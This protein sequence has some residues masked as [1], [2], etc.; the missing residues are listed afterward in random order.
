MSIYI[1]KSARY[2]DGKTGGAKDVELV[3]DSV[4]LSIIQGR[5][6]LESWDVTRIKILSIPEAPAPASISYADNPDARILI[7]DGEGWRNL[8]PIL[9]KHSKKRFSLPTGLGAFV[10]YIVVSF[11]ILAFLFMIFPRLIEVSAYLIPVKVEKMIGDRVAE[12]LIGDDGVCNNAEGVAALD[13]LV[14]RLE[15]HSER[16]IDYNVFV[17]NNFLEENA[18]SAP[19]GNIVFYSGLIEH[20]KSPDEVA[21]VLAHEMA[22]VELYH[23]TK[24][25]VRDLGVYAVLG[26]IFDQADYLKLAGFVNQARY[27]QEDEDAADKRGVELLIAAG[28]NPMG[29]AAFF[30]RKSEGDKHDSDPSD[31]VKELSGLINYFSSH[32]QAEHRIGR[33]EALSKG[34]AKGVSLS[35]KEWEALRSICGPRVKVPEKKTIRVPKSKSKRDKAIEL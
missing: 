12:R 31:D 26:M 34:A 11:S 7:E 21:G 35:D 32:P 24:G 13:K 6:T 22:H 15:E 30:K 27:S 5:D 16:K 19:G 14:T 25:L 8:Y 4:A 17:A 20:A 1:S 28:M 33:V 2:Y 10:G 18:F 23:T 9:V 29:L 3:L